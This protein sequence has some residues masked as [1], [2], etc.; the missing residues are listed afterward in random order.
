MTPWTDLE[1]G[2]GLVF[3]GE[4]GAPCVTGDLLAQEGGGLERVAQS[5]ACCQNAKKGQKTAAAH[6]AS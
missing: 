2:L 1:T 3:P 5:A 4:A 6:K